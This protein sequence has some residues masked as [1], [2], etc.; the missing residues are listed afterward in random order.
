MLVAAIGTGFFFVPQAWAATGQD[1]VSKGWTYGMGE[2]QKIFDTEIKKV[3]HLFLRRLISQK[4]QEAGVIADESLVERVITQI[5]RGN[6][7]AFKWE[8]EGPDVLISFN[9]EDSE[10]LRDAVNKFFKNLPDLIGQVVKDASRNILRRYKK[11]WKAYRPHDEF[12]F[13]NFRANLEGRWAEGLDRL[14]MLLDLSRNTGQE[15]DERLHRSKSQRNRHLRQALS[16]LHIRACQVTSEII[17]LM[18]NGY[19][20]GAMARW[21]T[22]HEIAVV[23]G[24]IADGG[25]PL[26]ERY[27]AH[28]AVE[29][30]RAMDEYARCHVPLGERPLS[31]RDIHHVTATFDA[32]SAKF[33]KYFSSMAGPPTI[34]ERGNRTSRISK[35]QQG[36]H[37]CV[38][39]TGWRVTMCM[40]APRASLTVSAPS[41]TPAS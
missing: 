15:Y 18:E 37:R 14:R 26:A 21:R 35:R 3:P 6:E 8:G 27:L 38:R 41:T 22:L 16:S 29:A 25:D 39:T 1:A 5:R 11:D 13:A 20:D 36:V 9:D 19:A 32:V 4:L 12:A 34:S 30:K 23:A 10:G 28:E 7:G 31:K 2:L 33:G 24:V 17:V 40:L